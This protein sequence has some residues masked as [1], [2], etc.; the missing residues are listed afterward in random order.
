VFREVE[1]NAFLSR[2]SPIVGLGMLI[3]I[4]DPEAFRE[5]RSC[6]TCSE[7]MVALHRF[8]KVST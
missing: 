4:E 7:N 2:S 3:V 5:R 8:G 6:Y 1:L